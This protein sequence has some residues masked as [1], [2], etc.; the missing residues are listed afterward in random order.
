MLEDNL[1]NFPSLL[2]NHEDRLNLLEHQVGLLQKRMPKSKPRRVFLL[3]ISMFL[4]AVPIVGAA[5]STFI[6]DRWKAM[7]V[8]AAFGILIG[9]T[10]SEFY[11]RILQG[12]RPHQ[13]LLLKDHR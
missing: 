11:M 7:V 6:E 3:L 13:S 4:I 1:P 2:V 8:V 10:I 12:P 5:A 9:R